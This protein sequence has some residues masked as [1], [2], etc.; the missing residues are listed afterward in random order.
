[1]GPKPIGHEVRTARDAMPMGPKPIGHE[2]RTARDRVLHA[3]ADAQVPGH[4]DFTRAA[5]V[6]HCSPKWA[7]RRISSMRMRR[8]KA[9]RSAG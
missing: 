9:S 2:V 3:H 7:P 8:R 6:V 5:K 4:A 1:M